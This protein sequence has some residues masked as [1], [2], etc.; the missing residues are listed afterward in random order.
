MKSLT[1]FLL[2]SIQIL[3]SASEDLDTDFCPKQD[4]ESCAEKDLKCC[5]ISQN[6]ECCNENEYWSQWPSLETS[7][8]QPRSIVKGIMKLVGIIVGTAIFVV[9]VCC[10]CCFCCPFCLFAK[11]RQG[12]VLRE[13]PAQTVPQQPLQ[14]QQP[15]YPPPNS[16]YPPQGAYP[17]PNPQYPPQGMPYPDNPPPYP[18]PPM[19]Q[20]PPLS[21]SEYGQQPAFNPNA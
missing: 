3:I 10:V 1:I 19:E 4:I 5:A 6:N 14:P 13:G 20:A 11:S 18:G 17:P 9:I 12:R 21:K 8:A 2:I 16:Q 15:A 7:E